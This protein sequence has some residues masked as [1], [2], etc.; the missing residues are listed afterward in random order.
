MSEDVITP[1]L[2]TLVERCQE[3][4][5]HA[6][7]V[8]AFLRHSDEIEDFP[9]LTEICRAIFDTS[10]ALE[11]RCD[12]PV[13]YFKMLTKKLGKFK[14]AVE[15][16]AGQVPEISTHTNFAQSVISLRACVRAL[17]ELLAQARTAVIQSKPE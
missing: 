11:T 13:G 8:R 16:F 7:V 10:R 2:K 14:V 3:T 4:M 15:V 9:E 17:D 5:A 12:D 6:W 1:D